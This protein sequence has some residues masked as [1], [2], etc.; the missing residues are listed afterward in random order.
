MTER[1]VVNGFYWGDIHTHEME[2]WV[3]NL[4]WG[5]GG[6]LDTHTAKYQFMGDVFSMH[7]RGHHEIRNFHE[8]Y[9]KQAEDEELVEDEIQV[10]TD[11]LNEADRPWCEMVIVPA[12]HD[13]HLDRW[14]N[15]ADFRLD[16]VNA[17]Y[18][19]WLQYHLLDAIDE[20]DK[21]F[22]ILEFATR[23]KGLHEGIRFLSMD[24]SFMTVGIENGLHGDKGQNGSRG[25]TVSLGKL[26]RPLNKGH[27]HTAAI[28]GNVYSAG[29]C[30]LRFGYMDGPNSHS[31][32]HIVNY[33]NGSR[34]IV[35]MWSGKWRA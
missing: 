10:T 24:E 26:G 11:F 27:D 8:R 23:E 1:P 25:S 34:A 15:E 7:T 13:R 32:S 30:S 12:N 16:T 14:L 6:M 2:P 28:R 5:N 9:R 35:T 3:R 18:F 21:D 22:N 19:C 33:E 17:K 20:G 29:A 4:V 31:V